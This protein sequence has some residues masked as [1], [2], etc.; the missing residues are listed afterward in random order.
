[1]SSKEI[2]ISRF[3]DSLPVEVANE[4]LELTLLNVGGLADDTNVKCAINWCGSNTG[5]STN[6]SGCTTNPTGCTTNPTGCNVNS[7]I[8][9]NCTGTNLP[10]STGT[11]KE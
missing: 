3:I 6:K 7:C 11:C 5:C 4:T 2:R 1:M 9:N 10:D 8:I